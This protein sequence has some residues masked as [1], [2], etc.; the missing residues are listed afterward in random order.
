MGVTETIDHMQFLKFFFVNSSFCPLSG[1]PKRPRRLKFMLN[2]W[3]SVNFSI[4]LL[5]LASSV[6]REKPQNYFCSAVFCSP[7][8]TIFE[9]LPK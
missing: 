9:V 8:E 2:N 1:L 7:V 6:A 5:S 4:R 3:P